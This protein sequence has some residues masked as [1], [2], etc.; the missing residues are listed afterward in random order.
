MKDFGEWRVS[1]D[2]WEVLIQLHDSWKYALPQ[3]GITTLDQVRSMTEDDLLA[4]DGVG[5]KTVRALRD[6]VAPGPA[7]PLGAGGEIV[8]TWPSWLGEAP[9]E[10]GA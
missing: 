10:A 5:Y 2:L 4:L 3:A 7:L 6:A 1:R 8:V 9:N